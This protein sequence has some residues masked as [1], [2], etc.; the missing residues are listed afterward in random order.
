MAEVVTT[1]TG[2][3]IE[4][5]EYP[6]GYTINGE[7]A[8]SVTQ[9]LRILDKPA[10]AWWNMKVG[11]EGFCELSKRYGWTEDGYP[12]FTSDDII[13]WLKR[14][15]L[16]PYYVSRKAADRGKY[17]HQALEQLSETGQV[18]DHRTFPPEGRGYVEGLGKW[19]AEHGQEFQASEVLVASAEHGFAGTFDLLCT[20]KDGRRA[21][22]DLKTS[23]GIYPEMFLQLEAYELAAVES[24]YRL[25]DVRMVVRT[26]ADGSWEAQE[27]YA[28][29]DQFLAI[30]GAYRAMEE[31]NPKKVA[32]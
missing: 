31:L 20:L 28:T 10:L 14:E 23:K 4:F 6:R 16:T 13:G 22:C 12:E 24:G 32:A 8:V 5:T 7:P 9:I 19:W 15:K 21:R 30:L 2:I 17:V 18:P 1:P 3:V 11:I 27:S 29:Q 25:S 26:A